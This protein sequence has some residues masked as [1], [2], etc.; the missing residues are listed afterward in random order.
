MK[1]LLE[2]EFAKGYGLTRKVPVSVNV[3][4]GSFS[5]CDDKACNSCDSTHNQNC[6]KIVLHVKCE[7]PIDVVDLEHF[8]DAFNDKISGKR[9]DLMMYDESKIVLCELTCSKSHLIVPHKRKDVWVPGKREYAYGQIDNTIRTLCHVALVHEAIKKRK[10]VAL[11]AYR[12]KDFPIVDDFIGKIVQPMKD[13]NPLE[14]S[15]AAM[16]LSTDMSEGFSFVQ[17]R[18]PDAYLW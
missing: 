3:Y 2:Q 4:G 18:Y 13:F 9:C 11:F 16:N 7:T 5:L 6:D 8:L 14:A 17:V 12:E 10:K 15:I 1:D